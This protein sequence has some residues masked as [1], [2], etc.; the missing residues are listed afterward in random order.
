MRTYE[1]PWGLLLQ[2]SENILVQTPNISSEMENS[3]STPS[4]VTT[5][6]YKQNSHTY[7]CG[8]EFG[9]TKSK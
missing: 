5:V 7:V 2:I 1:V 8:T 4:G 3:T 9:E 6:I